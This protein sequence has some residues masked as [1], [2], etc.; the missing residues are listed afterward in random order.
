MGPIQVYLMKTFSRGRSRGSL[1]VCVGGGVS[2]HKLISQMRGSANNIPME[3]GASTV[4]HVIFL[5]GGW[6]GV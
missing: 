1:C 5:V 3:T 2:D 6:S 4:T